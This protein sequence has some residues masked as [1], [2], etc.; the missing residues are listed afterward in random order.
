MDITA[1]NNTVTIHNLSDFNLKHIFLCGQCFRW[2]EN[3]DGSFTGVAMD[4][5]IKISAHDNN[6]TLFNTNLQEFNEIWLDYFDLKRNYSD[7]KKQVAIDEIMKK[8]TEYG[9]GIR[10]LRQNL[11]ETMISFIISAS[12]NIPRIKQIVARLCEMFGEKICFDNKVYYTFP[13]PEKMKG[14]TEDD[15]APVRSGFRA[16][17]IADAAEK[18]NSGELNLTELA[19]MPTAEAKEKLLTVKG[20]GSKVADCILLFGMGRFDVFPV[21]TWI[22]KAMKNLYP[23]QCE[24]IRNV[25]EAGET[26]FGE[27]CG[28]ANQYIFFYARDNKLF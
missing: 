22:D 1:E 5:V 16:K 10:I 18:V 8:A 25:R 28:L 11:W 4:R 9:F 12:N 15:L 27:N 6:Y 13:S 23:S 24:G 14:V 21:D 3:E 19:K 26:I 7:L 2:D 20:I 17:Y